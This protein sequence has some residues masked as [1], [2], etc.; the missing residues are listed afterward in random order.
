MNKNVPKKHIK[1]K[2]YAKAFEELKIMQ[3]KHSKVKDIN[4][5]KYTCQEYLK[6]PMVSFKEA[7]ILV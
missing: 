1:E 2:V 6:S 7:S 4:Y 5:E 3:S